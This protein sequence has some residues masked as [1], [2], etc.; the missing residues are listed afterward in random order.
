MTNLKFLE[1]HY[2]HF[3]TKN[4]PG[5]GFALVLEQRGAVVKRF[6]MN[7]TTLREH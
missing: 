1:I 4:S 2:S 5:Q 7:N 3:Q 6:N